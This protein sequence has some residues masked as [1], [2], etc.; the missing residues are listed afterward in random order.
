MLLTHL[1]IDANNPN[2]DLESNHRLAQ[3]RVEAGDLWVPR[4]ST[5]N[6]ADVEAF[7][8][9]GW[10]PANTVAYALL[11]LAVLAFLLPRGP[12]DGARLAAEPPVVPRRGRPRR[13]GL[14]L[15]PRQNHQR[16]GPLAAASRTPR[17]DNWQELG[18]ASPTLKASSKSDNWGGT[19]RIDSKE[20]KTSTN[21]AWVKVKL[22]AGHRTWRARRSS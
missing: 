21:T 13:R 7:A 6:P 2:R 10:S 15:L 1:L 5:P 19:I 17:S 14:H 8:G 20:S 12:A 18:L 9:S 22:P 3:A 11:G 4:G 16:Q